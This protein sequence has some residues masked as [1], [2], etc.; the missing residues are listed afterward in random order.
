MS[1]R[2]DENKGFYI[3]LHV[4]HNNQPFELYES[5]GVSIY[6]EVHSPAHILDAI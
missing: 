6:L 1:I 4:T 3:N 5:D 2:Y